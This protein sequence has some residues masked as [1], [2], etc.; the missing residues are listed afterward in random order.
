MRRHS[1]I[2]RLGLTDNEEVVLI[3]LDSQVTTIDFFDEENHLRYGL[4][5]ILDQ[6]TARDMYPPE[7]A[8]DLAILAA[9]ITAADTRIFRQTESQD[10]W[11]REIDIFLPV[12]D[13]VLWAA[14]IERIERILNFLTGDRWSIIFR[15]RQDGLESLIDRSGVQVEPPFT[16]VCLFSGGLDSFVGAIDLLEADESPFFVSHYGDVSTSSQLPCARL[17]GAVYGPMGPRHARANV[18]FSGDLVEGS[19][20]E[21]TTRG[22][23]FL[24][25]SLAALVA[26]AFNGN[27]PIYVP[28]NGLISLNIPLDPLR[29]GALSTRTTHPFYIARWQELIEDLEIGGRFVNP[30]RFQTKGEMLAGCANAQFLQSNMEATISCSSIAKA[31]WRGLPP[32]HCGYCVPCLIRRAAIQSAFGDDPTEYTINDLAAQPLNAKQVEAESVRSFHMMRHRLIQQPGLASILTH[33]TGP[34]SDYSEDEVA[35]YTAVFQR[36]I[37]EVGNI[38]DNVVVNQI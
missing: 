6:L 10:S 12:A 21:P 16:S 33:K 11:T 30:Y 17:I 4:R 31:R 14:N 24:F 13:P 37:A 38:V 28:E 35:N 5:Q 2:A 23:S 3:D 18:G 19:E 36:G 29:L 8:I 26:S 34:L 15:S 32:G 9:T 20:P 7:R 22:R 1:I 25:I 27:P